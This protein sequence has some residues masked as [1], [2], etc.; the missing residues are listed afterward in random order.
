VRNINNP[1]DATAEPHSQYRQVSSLQ[2]TPVVFCDMTQR[3][4]VD[5]Y[6][7]LENPSA[8]ILAVGYC[9]FSKNVG[10]CFMLNAIQQYDV[11]VGIQQ[12]SSEQP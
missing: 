12:S 1:A 10:S 4:A 2:N 6:D 11:H 8:S 5:I 3:N 7:L 9:P